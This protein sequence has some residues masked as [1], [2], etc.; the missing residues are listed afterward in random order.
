[1]GATWLQAVLHKAPHL[2]LVGAD[3][4][5]DGAVPQKFD[6]LDRTW[7]MTLYLTSKAS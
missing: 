4:M 1:M 6:R 3:Y 7:E 2:E 5:P